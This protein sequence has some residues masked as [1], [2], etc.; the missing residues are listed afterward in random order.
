MFDSR[1][2]KCVCSTY[3]CL[4]RRLL[5]KSALKIKIVLGVMFLLGAVGI[6]LSGDIY[7]VPRIPSLTVGGRSVDDIVVRSGVIM[8]EAETICSALDDD[9]LYQLS[10]DE[11]I[12]KYYG[13]E[14]KLKSG[15]K[16]C[17]IGDK[18][19]SLSAAPEIDSG[20]A[21]VPLRAAAEWLECDVEWDSQSY[22]ASVSG[23]PGRNSLDG[24]SPTDDYRYYKFNGRYN[25]FDIFGN[26]KEYICTESVG[27]SDEKCERYADLINSFAAAVPK[28]RTYSILV[29]TSAEFYASSEKKPNYTERFRRIYSRLNR[30]IYGVDVV[31]ALSKH[32][33]EHIYFNT[34]H[35]WTQL[36]AYYAYREFLNYGFESIKEPNDFKEETIEYYQGSFLEYTKDTDG[37]KYMQDSYDRLEMY[38]PS[39]EYIGESYYDSGLT[40][41]ILPMSAIDTNFKNYDCFMD[42]DFPIEVF[43]TN[44]KNGRRLCIVKDSFGNA[45][46]VWALNNYEEV[47][48]IDYRRFNDYD[49]DSESYRG[50]SISD[51]YNIAP[52]DD[53]VILNY[54]VTV[55]SEAELSALEKM[56]K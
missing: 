1:T 41:Y 38:Y 28:A 30:G 19:Q 16:I 2:L 10:D 36:G 22:K 24:V 3:V 49:G 20:L 29:P 12:I 21:L 48:V 53:L 50:F 39:V 31:S 52:F 14:L 7:I 54:P 51:F 15:R 9:I 35:H 47:Y 17:K 33:G 5:L 44:N 42:G 25:G 11:L 45:F 40:E 32:A 8:L 4:R 27:I 23:P 46:A 18:V 37:Y 55:S 34:D 13:D 43:K 56:A 6:M 26:G